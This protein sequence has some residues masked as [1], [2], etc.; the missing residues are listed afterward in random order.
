MDYMFDLIISQFQ[1]VLT[2]MIILAVIWLLKRK[3][4]FDESHQPV[5]DRLVTELALPAIIFSG[6]VSAD[7]NTEWLVPSLIMFATIVLCGLVA[8]GFCR[9][10][11]LSPGKTGT[12]VIVA[13]FGSTATFASPLIEIL[14]GAE[15]QAVDV[16]LLIGNFGVAVPFFTLGVLLA[17]YFGAKEH[18]KDTRFFPVL[19][20]FIATPIFIAF[21]LGFIASIISSNYQIPGSDVLSDIFSTFFSQIHN[22]VELL[23]WIAIGLLLRP[24][25]LKKLFP[26]LALI[27]IIQMMLQPAIA[28]IFAYL[29]G[30]SM[31]VQEVIFLT[32]AM[33]SGAIAAVLADRYGCDGQLAASLVICTYI[34]SLV[35]LP[36]MVILMNA[37]LQ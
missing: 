37:I 7:L 18:E 12:I 1:L 24:F 29:F 26:Y 17:F 15:S 23:V 32:A 35:S 11:R 5:F 31:V 3:G 30:Q 34:I 36:F 33:P 21:I 20:E 27:V 25:D 10:F 13:A 9:Y 28:V 6:L 14:Y 22:S 19:K 2:F 8:Y 16:G 4:I